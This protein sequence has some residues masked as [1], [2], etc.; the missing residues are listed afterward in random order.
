MSERECGKTA[1]I[2]I[3]DKTPVLFGARHAVFWPFLTHG[4]SVSLQCI[5]GSLNQEA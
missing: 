2:G 3:S 5:D 4:G 1:Q